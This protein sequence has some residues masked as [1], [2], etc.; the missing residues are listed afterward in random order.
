[1]RG[2]VR[3]VSIIALMRWLLPR[4]RPAVLLLVLLCA[5]GVAAASGL[6]LGAG[7]FPVQDESNG[8]AAGAHGWVVVQDDEGAMLLHLPPRR[9]WT[10]DGVKQGSEAGTFRRAAQL[11]RAPEAI[12]AQ[13]DRLYLVFPPEAGGEGRG[14]L[15]R[16][17]SIRARQVGMGDLWSYEPAGRMRTHAPLPGEPELLGLAGSPKGVVALLGEL[18]SE[19]VRPAVHVLTRGSWQRLALPEATVRSRDAEHESDPVGA[20]ITGPQGL[21]L[22]SMPDGVGLL[23]PGS[24]D[25]S[26]YWAATLSERDGGAPETEGDRADSGRGSDRAERRIT[27]EWR[28]MPLASA[29]DMDERVLPRSTPVFFW[30]DRLYSLIRSRDGVVSVRSADTVYRMEL[31]RVPGVDRRFAAAPLLDVE[32]L[33]LVWIDQERGE[34]ADADGAEDSVGTEPI[35]APSFARVTTRVFIHELSLATGRE[36]HRGPGHAGSPISLEDFQIVVFAIMAMTVLVIVFVLWPASGMGQQVKLPAGM[37]LAEPSRRVIAGL[38]D[39]AVASILTAVLVGMPIG[40]VLT[41]G[42]AFAER[43][44]PL[45]LPLLLLVGFTVCTL[46]EWRFGRSPGKALTGCRVITVV[47]P[48]NGELRP[49]RVTLSQAAIRNACRWMVPPLVMQAFMDPLH[50]HRGDIMART[51]VVVPRSG[52]RDPDQDSDPERG[53]GAGGPDGDPSGHRADDGRNS[54]ASYPDPRDADRPEDRPD[55]PKN[56][57]SGRI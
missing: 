28:W 23:V 33:A 3:P 49:E 53:R 42:G 26:G 19:R 34:D 4:F 16:V 39:F 20:P 24:G 48:V 45:L 7:S 37:P 2:G 22:F 5:S 46:G 1:M 17:L 51:A 27:P 30:G 38:V 10:T 40:D 6:P 57:V 43:G 13:G 32:R 44:G 56:S 35:A 11:R 21:R 47:K 31:A 14:S 29:Q 50:R 12:A 54:S 41:F 52:P 36:V 55:G 15:R 8:E 9:V 25:R 18:E